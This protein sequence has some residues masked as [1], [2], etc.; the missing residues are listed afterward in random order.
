MSAPGAPPGDP[1]LPLYTQQRNASPNA[2]PVSRHVETGPHTASSGSTPATTSSSLPKLAVERDIRTRLPTFLR[3]FAG[4]RPLG[5]S[6]PFAPLPFP[7]FSW[8]RHI[9]LQYEVW[10][11]SLIATFIGILLI[12]ATMAGTHGMAPQD[13]M[14]IVASFGASAVLSYGAI[15][16][17][18]A[19]PRHLVGGQVVCAI[20]GVVVT[21][22]FRLTSRSHFEAGWVNGEIPK[23]VWINGA[24]AMALSSL[25]MQVTG[26]VHPPGGATALIAATTPGAITMSWRYIYIVLVSSLLMLGWALIIN[27]GA[28]IGRQSER[29]L[30]LCP[31]RRPP[32]LPSLLAARHQGLRPAL[33]GHR[34]R[35]PPAAADRGGRA[36]GRRRGPYWRLCSHG[37]RAV[38]S[39]R[40]GSRA[41]PAT[42]TAGARASESSVLYPAQHTELA[43]QRESAGLCS[44]SRAGHVERGQSME[45]EGERRGRSR[46]GGDDG[47][48]AACE[49]DAACK[50]PTPGDAARER[51]EGGGAR[52]VVGRVLGICKL[53]PV[54]SISLFMFWH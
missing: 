31:E 46:G 4:Y 48:D 9:P 18:L 30:T 47:D 21:R 28:S 44:R 50:Q 41:Q 26:T 17:P 25:A 11:L 6:P 1:P 10:L 32:T 37:A 52:A 33:Y 8:L 20:T 13:T 14:L 27:V 51:P 36:D 24:L 34:R 23:I 49:R 15:D 35:G 7:P 53:P 12:E 2:K 42:T 16:S 43:T 38:A 19:Q 40:R 39:I 54:I 5:S 29:V 45:R 3:R 22:L